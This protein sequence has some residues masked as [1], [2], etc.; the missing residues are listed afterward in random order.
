M[1]QAVGLKVIAKMDIQNDA[2]EVSTYDGHELNAI[3]D[4]SKYDNSESIVINTSTSGARGRKNVRK[5]YV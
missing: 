1:F 2:L 4:V 5:Y 3:L